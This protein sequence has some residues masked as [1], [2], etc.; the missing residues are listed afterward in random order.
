MVKAAGDMNDIMSM[1][2]SQMQSAMAEQCEVSNYKAIKL[3]SAQF[4]GPSATC[5]ANQKYACKVINREAA[6]D[7]KVYV[8]LV[9]HDDTSDVSIATICGTNL[10]E[11]TKAIC[12]NAG[13]SD[14][15][16]AEYCSAD[17]KG[18]EPVKRS[19]SQASDESEA[20]GG[21]SD[22]MMEGAKKLKGLF[23]F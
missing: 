18:G 5:A 1:A 3:I 12:A 19:S 16:L 17:G 20:S 6:K 23:G 15:D 14:R 9:K 21:A 11:T 22:S 2:K 7:P 4:F 10:A 13:E 8:K